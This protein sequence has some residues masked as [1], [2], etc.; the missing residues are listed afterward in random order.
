MLC[1]PPINQ[2][3]VTPLLCLEGWRG[4]AG[5]RG[6]RLAVPGRQPR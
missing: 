3:P 1:S 6:A 5:G 2:A 4:A